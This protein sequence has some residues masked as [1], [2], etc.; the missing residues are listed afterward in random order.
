MLA[1]SARSIPLAWAGPAADP[2]PPLPEEKPMLGR[3]EVSAAAGSAASLFLGLMPDAASAETG[4]QL[5]IS[6]LEKE[7]AV[8][9][10]QETAKA[11]A[12]AAANPPVAEPALPSSFLPTGTVV[13]MN[14]DFAILCP[15]G[16]KTRLEKY[17]GRLLSSLERSFADGGMVG[18]DFASLRVAQL[19]LPTLAKTGGFV[20]RP[21]DDTCSDWKEVTVGD[22]TANTCADWIMKAFYKSVESQV[23]APLNMKIEILDAT[24]NTFAEQGVSQLKWHASAT[25]PPASEITGAGADQAQGLNGKVVTF[26]D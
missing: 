13:G 15:S 7:L 25:Y 3:R 5:R 21:S 4:D 12:E 9:R 20:P 14:Q 6:E 24:I 23:G 19:N 8:L 22:I 2:R 1:H 16:W 17:P 11:A 18:N 10:D 26:S